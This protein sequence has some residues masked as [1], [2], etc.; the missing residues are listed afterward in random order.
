MKDAKFETMTF[1]ESDYIEF[2]NALGRE[3]VNDAKMW[4]DIANFIRI[5][6]KNGYQVRVWND[7]LTTAVEYDHLDENIRQSRLEW[8]PE[9][10]ESADIPSTV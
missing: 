9:E 8:I 7:G 10:G 4:D 6:I 2:Y 5:A 1:C 3:D